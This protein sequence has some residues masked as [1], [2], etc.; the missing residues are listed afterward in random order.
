[1]AGIIAKGLYRRTVG[2]VIDPTWPSTM[3]C[4]EGHV[5]GKNT[6]MKTLARDVKEFIVWNCNISQFESQR[7][8]GAT[9]LL[10]SSSSTS[11]PALQTNSENPTRCFPSPP[12]SPSDRSA[13]SALRALTVGSAAG[14]RHSVT[15]VWSKARL[16]ITLSIP[17]ESVAFGESVPIKVQ[18]H[19]RPQSSEKTSVVLVEG[20]ITV[21]QIRH[22]RNV[23]DKEMP[24]VQPQKMFTIPVTSTMTAAEASGVEGTCKEFMIKIPNQT[25]ESR[26]SYCPTAFHPTIKSKYFDV[27]HQISF[28][29]KLRLSDQKDRQAS[30]VELILP[31]RLVNPRPFVNEN[32]QEEPQSEGLLDREQ[33]REI[34]TLPD[35]Q[36][37]ALT[38]ASAIQSEE[39]APEYFAEDRHGDLNSAQSAPPTSGEQ[40]DSVANR[41]NDV[42]LELPRYSEARF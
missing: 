12:S 4:A 28:D 17:S 3:T 32:R 37:Q 5:K 19:V 22:S 16:P 10:S 41:Q 23:Y 24:N 31:I 21:Q 33:N 2:T 30:K 6:R 9:S 35:Y 7:S 26:V 15:G 8:V 18:F 42:D 14:P 27:E 38:T 40:L 34:S 36:D 39:L 25:L 1:M 13:T 20:R 11:A 29:L